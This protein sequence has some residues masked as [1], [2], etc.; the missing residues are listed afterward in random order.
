VISI[1]TTDSF[2]NWQDTE[3]IMVS[4]RM[5]RRARRHFKKIQRSKT[6]FELQEIASSIQTDLDKRHLTYDEALMLGNLIQTRA[7]QVPGDTI[8]YAISDRDA[9]RRT[10]E[11]YLR[12]ALLT[13]T[14]QLLLWEERRRLGISE[15]EHQSLL[16]Q[17]LTQWKRQGR[18]VTIDRFDKPSGGADSV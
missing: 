4:G 16:E 12:D 15:E 14:E 13:R 18:N 10:L 17:L 6:K 9:Y 2:N 5:S 3:E 8:V 11:L 7:D 1:N